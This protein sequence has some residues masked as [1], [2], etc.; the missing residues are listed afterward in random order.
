MAVV[1]LR[2]GIYVNSI[3]TVPD[4]DQ[5]A[6]YKYASLFTKSRKENWTMSQ[7]Q[8]ASEIADAKERDA[9]LLK[10]YGQQLKDYNDRL[11]QL[12]KDIAGA[13]TDVAKANSATQR[14]ALQEATA[15]Q[16]LAVEWEKT[17][18][19]QVSVAGGSKSSSKS[20]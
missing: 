17:K 10:V 8:A 11:Q 19:E 16:K 18:A 3:E 5:T 14:T 13:G 6:A 7:R 4:A 2:N 1:Q 9:A 12:D 20:S 15:R